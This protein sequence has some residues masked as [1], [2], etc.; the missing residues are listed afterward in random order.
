[1]VRRG[2]SIPQPSTIDREMPHQVALSDDIC[3]DRNLNT[4]PSLLGGTALPAER[5]R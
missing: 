2:R 4:D 5:G 3:T 1:M